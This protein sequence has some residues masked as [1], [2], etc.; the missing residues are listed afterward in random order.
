KSVKRRG[1]ARPLPPRFP[2][3]SVPEGLEISG[4]GASRCSGA[5]TSAVALLFIDVINKFASPEASS[6]HGAEGV[7]C[8]LRRGVAQ[9]GATTSPRAFPHCC[10]EGPLPI[11][12]GGDQN[13]SVVRQFRSMPGGKRSTETG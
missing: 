4:G 8:R 12:L 3:P 9:G 11:G 7:A 13:V 5:G 10:T 6:S 2:S 1:S